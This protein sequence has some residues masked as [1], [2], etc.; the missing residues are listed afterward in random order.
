MGSVT[1]SQFYSAKKNPNKMAL[2]ELVAN[3]WNSRDECDGQYG[4]TTLKCS[5]EYT[6]IPCSHNEYVILL[7]YRK[8]L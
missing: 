3:F 7:N 2:P 5:F 6:D 8:L 4:R 1:F